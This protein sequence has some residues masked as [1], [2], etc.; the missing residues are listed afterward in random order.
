VYPIEFIAISIPGVKDTDK[1][2]DGIDLIELF[3]QEVRV[4]DIALQ[5]LHGRHEEKR[6]MSFRVS[7]EDRDAMTQRRQSPGEV[8]TDKSGSAQD[9]NSLCHGCVCINI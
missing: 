4:V 1:V 6:P 5:Q 3:V 2:D 8:P 9:A 7:S